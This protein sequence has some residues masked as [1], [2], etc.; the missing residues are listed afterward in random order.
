MPPKKSTREQDTTPGPYVVS[1]AMPGDGRPHM[2]K[3]SSMV[4]VAGALQMKNMSSAF[5]KEDRQSYW[6]RRPANVD[7]VMEE[8]Q[9]KRRRLYQKGAEDLD[10]ESGGGQNGDVD[11]MEA[12]DL[13]A[14]N[15]KL[16][17]ATSKE[18]Q[19]E[20]DDQDDNSGNSDGEDRKTDVKGKSREN[21]SGFNM[22][23]NP[24]NNL[25]PHVYVL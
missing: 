3:Y 9:A 13:K 15:A 17:D 12:G 21:V 23:C 6:N 16:A 14:V 24:G 18:E 8:L 20:E 4:G 11:M 22:Q 7:T 5:M 19:P 10:D 2:F 1:N 25:I